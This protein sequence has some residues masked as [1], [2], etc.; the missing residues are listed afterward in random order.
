MVHLETLY[1]Q[2]ALEIVVAET[3][4][5]DVPLGVEGYAGP[6]RRGYRTGVYLPRLYP[7]LAVGG[8]P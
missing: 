8:L 4:G 5:G 3:D 2:F 1:G 6:A 7:Y